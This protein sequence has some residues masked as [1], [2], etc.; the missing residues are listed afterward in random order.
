MNYYSLP[1]IDLHCH[2]D[3]S[4]RKETIVDIAKK[5]GLVLPEDLDRWLVA[6]ETCGSLD[7]Y[8]TCFDWP[9]KV[10][11]TKEAIKR[12]TFEVFEDAALEQVKYLEVRFGPL[13]H[14]EKGL[15]I[16][17]VIQSVVE[18]MEKATSQY[19]IEGGIIVSILKTMAFDQI[20]DVIDAASLYID[21][22][23]VAIDLA[24]S[25]LPGF[26][27]D[28]IDYIAYAKQKGLH[29]TIHAG[30]NGYGQNVTDA[31]LLLHAE[32]IGHG[33]YIANDSKAYALTK[34][35]EVLLEICPTSNVQTKGVKSMETHPIRA[36]YDDDV[37]ISINTDNR[38]VSNTTMTK[39]IELT[40]ETFQMNE[41]DYKKIYRNAV[42]KAFTSD[43]IKEKLLRYIE[44]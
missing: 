43:S 44:K 2:I 3:G 27:H 33:I 36:F 30:E 6:P 18:G 14:L 24:G 35:Q 5:E 34:E 23:V 31:I 16:E 4:V 19:D 10:M 22:G 15:S 39:E 9:N 13:L 29:V 7:E 28:F 41:E 1:K 40:M 26:S 38:T 21:R 8:L 11:Q 32:R 20:N 17:E 37:L 25:E 12:I 42:L